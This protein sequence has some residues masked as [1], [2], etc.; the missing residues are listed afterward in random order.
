VVGDGGG[1]GGGGGG[2]R[3]QVGARRRP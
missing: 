3:G 1:G 2:V